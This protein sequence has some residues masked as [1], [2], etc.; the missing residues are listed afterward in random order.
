[1]SAA[2]SINQLKEEI[3]SF[4]EKRFVFEKFSINYSINL[5][6]SLIRIANKALIKRN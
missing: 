3:L 6:K 1:M 2:S 4:E 5:I